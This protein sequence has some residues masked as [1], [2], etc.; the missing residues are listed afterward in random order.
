MGCEEWGVGEIWCLK[1][2]FELF[3]CKKESTY[4]EIEKFSKIKNDNNISGNNIIEAYLEWE[5]RKNEA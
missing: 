5:N 1:D 2:I 3:K 4:N